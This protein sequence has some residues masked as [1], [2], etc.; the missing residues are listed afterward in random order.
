MAL[1]MIINM[2]I[3]MMNGIC[4]VKAAAGEPIRGDREIVAEEAEIVRRIFR[5]FAAGKSPEASVGEPKKSTIKGSAVR[6]RSAK[7]R[8]PTRTSGVRCAASSTPSAWTAEGVDAFRLTDRLSDSECATLMGGT[9]QKVYG[10]APSN[11]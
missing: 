11:Q 2:I 10:W 5:G 4:Q 3:L 6:A 8:S 7:S 1:Y 9:L